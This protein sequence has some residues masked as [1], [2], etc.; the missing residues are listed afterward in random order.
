LG[1]RFRVKGLGLLGF[2]TSSLENYIKKKVSLH[3][4]LY[5]LYVAA[6]LF[7]DRLLRLPG[8][9]RGL[10]GC[11]TTHENYSVTR[12]VH[13]VHPSDGESDHVDERAGVGGAQRRR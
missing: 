11:S 3:Y 5:S 13:P 12:N 2:G 10:W 9:P 8:L 7:R 1:N 6:L 4:A